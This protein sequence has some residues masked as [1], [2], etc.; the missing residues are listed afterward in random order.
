MKGRR[1][2]RNES[3][4]PTDTPR[5][6]EGTGEKPQ[7][8]SQTAAVL[9]LTLFI[10]LQTGGGKEAEASEHQL[11]ELRVEFNVQAALVQA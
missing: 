3:A 9:P 4:S 10:T 5:G 6:D 7:R 11:P 8:V 1:E 2:E